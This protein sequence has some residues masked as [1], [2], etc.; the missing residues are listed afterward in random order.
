MKV[1]S[2]MMGKFEIITVF[3]S[4]SIRYKLRRQGFKPFKWQAYNDE[5]KALFKASARREELLAAIEEMH[6][7]R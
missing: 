7:G 1:K 2:S 6:D 3:V 4:D 5:G